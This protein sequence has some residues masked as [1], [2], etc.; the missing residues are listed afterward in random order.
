MLPLSGAVYI[1]LIVSVQNTD[2][3]ETAPAYA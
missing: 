3:A 2:A 1:V